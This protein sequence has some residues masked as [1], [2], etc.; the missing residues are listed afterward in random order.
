MFTWKQIYWNPVL[1]FS[2]EN[3]N[4]TIKHGLKFDVKKINFAVRTCVKTL[5]IELF[6]DEI[7][8]R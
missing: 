5:E 3:I 2:S 7:V 6:I 1:L 8:S 4:L